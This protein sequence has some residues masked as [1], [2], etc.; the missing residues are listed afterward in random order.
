MYRLDVEGITFPN[1][2]PNQEFEMR[3]GTGRVAEF[4]QVFSSSKRV[5]TEVSLSGRVELQSLPILLENV[6]STATSINNWKLPTG[7]TPNT[8]IH[9]EAT[10]AAVWNKSL[11]LHFVSPTAV[12]DSWSMPGSVCTN[13]SLTADMTSNSGRYDYS[14]TFQSQYAVSKG[15][16]TLST[17]I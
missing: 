16:M 3:S 2:S 7:F 8:I 5:L 12:A 17:C 9:D 14:A 11:T 15:A 6:F 4:G 1:F 10:G 13:L